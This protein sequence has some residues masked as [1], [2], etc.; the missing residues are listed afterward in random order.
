MKTLKTMI[1]TIL[2]LSVLL[3]IGTSSQAY[4][5]WIDGTPLLHEESMSLLRVIGRDSRPAL[6]PGAE[7]VGNTP[8]YKV[9]DVQKFYAL[10]TTNNR[11]YVLKATCYT[12]SD[13][14]YIFVEKGISVTQ[15]KIDALANSFNQIYDN[16]IKIYGAPPEKFSNDPRI[17]FLIMDIIDGAKRNG[18]MMLGYFS[19][20]DQFLNTEL[21]P[22]TRMKSNETNMLYIDYV[23]LN[24]DKI[25]A[26]SIVAHEFTHLVQWARDPDESTWVDEGI[27]V[28]TE[29][30]LGYDVKDQISAF[31]QNSSISLLDWTNTVEDYGAA[32]LFFDYLSERFGGTPLISDI[33]K[34]TAQDVD[35]IVKT[36]SS[37]G[38]S[39]SFNEVFS[40][41]VIANYLDDP[42]LENGRYGYSNLDVKLNP[43]VVESQYPIIQ[44]QSSV[45]PWSAQ[46]IE[47]TK[48]QDNVL[49]LNVSENNQNDINARLI[50]VDSEGKVSVSSI[51]LDNTASVSREDSKA[52]LVTTSQPDPPDSKQNKSVYAYSAESR[53]VGLAVTPSGSKITTWGSIKK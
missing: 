24:S 38:M 2:S 52:I 21:A 22:L 10:N 34:N 19:P 16:I 40:D 53:V 29:A 17:D 46:Y 1:I 5:G 36:L 3:A 41:W 27:A 15:N 18:V 7:V 51:K 49:S 9:G 39:T 31:E 14:A 4:N 32:Y 42:K 6:A 45:L 8:M 12:V 11:Q 13:K 35:G 47:F 48:G 44:K 30:I 50:G 26:D 33:V 43:S 25:S 20:I 28:Y 37:H 23:S